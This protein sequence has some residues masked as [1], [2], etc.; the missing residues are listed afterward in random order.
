MNR[1]STITLYLPREI[2]IPFHW[3]VAYLTGAPCYLEKGLVNVINK[4]A[5]SQE[6]GFYY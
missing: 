6:T 1:V 2:S 3:G 4:P 5:R